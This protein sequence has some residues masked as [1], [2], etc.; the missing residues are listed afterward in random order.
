[1]QNIDECIKNVWLQEQDILNVVHKV[2]V[3]HNLKYSLIFGTLLGAVR[4]GGFIPWDDDIDIIMPREDY[5][6]LI[7][8][9][10]DV[11]PKGYI[12]QNKRTDSD[13]T[14]NFTKIRKDN[15]TFIQDEV[16]K[17][18]SY[19]T[20]VFIDIFPA[21]RVAPKGIK[22]TL[23]YIASAFNLLTARGFSSGSKGII[24][25]VEKIV[26]CLPQKLQ[27][28]IYHMTEKMISKYSCD[29]KAAWYSPNTIK[30]CK[31]YFDSDMFENMTTIKFNNKEYC[32]VGDA[33]KVLKKT[34]GNYMQYPP[35]EERVWTHHPIMVDFNHNYS[36]LV[37][38]AGK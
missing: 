17:T 5:E 34:Y 13:F 21:D 11:V 32:C 15:T 30:E 26:L 4:H 16:E 9:W 38:R 35:V 18:K 14:Q 29:K 1:M 10:N 23:Q 28:S 25:F 3:E 7:S 33:D 36:D 24:G 22:R 37:E 31:R 8:I 6:K 12:L 19:H 2:C 27:I 20:G